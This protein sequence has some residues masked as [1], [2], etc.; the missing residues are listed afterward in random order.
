MYSTTS[1]SEHSATQH[2]T[3]LPTL[4][5]GCGVEENLELGAWILLEGLTLFDVA[6]VGWVG[7]RVHGGYRI[8]F[9][10]TAD[11]RHCPMSFF[12]GL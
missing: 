7:V 4:E 2:E 3:R 5:S 9:H 11:Y 6:W 10:H 12:T 1:P 8:S